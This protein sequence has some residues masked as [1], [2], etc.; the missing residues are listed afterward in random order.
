[1]NAAEI[2]AAFEVILDQALVFHGFV[3]GVKWHCLYPALTLVADPERTD[4]WASALGI[5]FHEAR[6]QT[7]ANDIS[8]L[9]SDLVVSAVGPGWTPFVAED[10]DGPAFKVPL[11]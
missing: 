3:W 6:A 9:F 1:M 11:A 7:E 10:G 2:A 8:R 5:P 4:D